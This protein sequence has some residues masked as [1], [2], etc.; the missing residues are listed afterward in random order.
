LSNPNNS[1]KDLKVK[2]AMALKFLNNINYN[3]KTPYLL[4]PLFYVS[5]IRLF[6]GVFRLN[7]DLFMHGYIV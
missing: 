6:M 2:Q 5:A 1:I 3:P 7:V 4:N